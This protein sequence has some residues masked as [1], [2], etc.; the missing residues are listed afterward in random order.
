MN[1]RAEIDQIMGQ[2]EE[3]ESLFVNRGSKYTNS[4]PI[5]KMKRWPT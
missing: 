4:E 3:I 1:I 5:T 2:I